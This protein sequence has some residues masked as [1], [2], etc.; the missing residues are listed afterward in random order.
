MLFVLLFFCASVST[1]TPFP[2]SPKA[3]PGGGCSP[4]Q[5]DSRVIFASAT[6]R[7]ANLF[8]AAV[9]SSQT[10]LQNVVTHRKPPG[11]AILEDVYLNRGNTVYYGVTACRS[12]QHS[13]PSQRTIRIHAVWNVEKSEQSQQMHAACF[14]QACFV[15]LE[16]L[17][18]RK[19]RDLS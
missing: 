11:R 13:T 15:R 6:A 16:P 1:G 2:G 10:R 8:Y 4:V 3:G 18:C 19:L 9:F 7:L 14:H 12:G 5:T 17:T